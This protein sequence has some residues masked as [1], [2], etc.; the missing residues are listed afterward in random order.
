MNFIA[1]LL[2]LFKLLFKSEAT[3]D[4]DLET[5]V[6]EENP[7]PDESLETEEKTPVNIDLVAEQHCEQLICKKCGKEYSSSG[8]HDIGICKECMAKE[9]FIGGPLGK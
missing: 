5:I 6:V 1:K 4:S 3:T 9:N 7:K 8:L 2:D